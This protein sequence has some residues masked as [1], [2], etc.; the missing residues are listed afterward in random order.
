MIKEEIDAMES[1]A[2]EY[3]A[4]NPLVPPGYGYSTPT[5]FKAGWLARAEWSPKTTFTHEEYA[6]KY[7]SPCVPESIEDLTR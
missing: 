7:F 3:T 6:E 5:D 1:A 2:K 4:K